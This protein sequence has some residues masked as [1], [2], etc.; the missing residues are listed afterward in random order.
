MKPEEGENRLC[1][2]CV[3]EPFLRSEIER[4][5]VESIC[6]YCKLTRKLFS[7]E[8]VADEVDRVIAEHFYQTATEPSGLEYIAAKEGEK[9][10][11]RA[12][13]PV[14]ELIEELARINPEPA[15]DLQKVLYHRHYDF[16]SAQ[17]G[18][19][20]QYETDSQYA[21]RDFETA[22][23]H[24]EWKAFERVLKSQERYFSKT[25][26]DFLSR[27]FN[28]IADYKTHSG[29]SVIV[30]AGPGKQI[31][32]LFRARVFQS[33][34][35]LVEALKRPDL[36][37]GPPPSLVATTGRMN[38]YG[39]SV[40]YGALDPATALAEIRPPVGS[41]VAI[42]KFELLRELL[43]LDVLAMR[44]L[45]AEGSL[46]DPAFKR[47]QERASFLKWLSRRIA[48]PVMPGDEPFEYLPT[49]AVAD[50]LS[51]RAHPP[52]DGIIYPSVQAGKT[53]LNVV[54][55][56]KAARVEPMDVLEGTK[57]DAELYEFEY[58]P[59]SV[60]LAPR[61][62]EEVPA[63]I[64]PP[65]N[66]VRL[67]PEGCSTPQNAP[68]GSDPRVPALK[69]DA[70]QVWVYQIRAAKFES[71]RHLVSRSR[72]KAHGVTEAPF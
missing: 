39:I 47:N 53:E 49:Q 10:W 52:L 60:T 16:D 24:A 54:L 31:A 64:M 8:E 69:V 11:E 68:S 35:S 22:A 18:E 67:E 48:M 17:I 40:F 72:I 46:F 58:D 23:A 70:S 28:G 66:T 37:I 9:D 12:G 61:V 25:A 45:I 38:A 36:T 1:F 2:E 50:F 59:P 44:T 65:T 43:L 55:F 32:A 7:I 26:E 33:D 62:M 4:D 71:D 63:E 51:V 29:N 15:T 57:I 19:E 30:E 5:G 6:S 34:E 3:G 13:Q 41:K 27:I 14:I 20:L 42:A 56:H 21:E